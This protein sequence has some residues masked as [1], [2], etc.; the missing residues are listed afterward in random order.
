MKKVIFSAIVMMA[1][2]GTS[3]GS[4]SRSKFNLAYKSI[5]KI[6]NKCAGVWNATY[7]YARNRGFDDRSATAIAGAAA[8]ECLKA[9]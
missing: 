5:V 1:F 8:R 4:N 3:A 7:I 9:I 2:V 6:D